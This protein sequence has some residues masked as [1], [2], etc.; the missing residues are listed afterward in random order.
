MIIIMK[1]IL[2]FVPFLFCC[3]KVTFASS[4]V[5]L[6]QDSGRVLKSENKDEPML[7]ASISKIMTCIIA[8]ENGD[9]NKMV[10]ADKSIL[11]AVG[12]SIYIEIGESITLK[13]LLY[14]MMLRSGNDAAVLIANS[15][16]GDMKTFSE[17]M[18]QYAK[19]I[20]MKN[21]VFYNSNGLE[22]EN[23]IGNKS[24]AYDMAILTSYAMKNKM[25]RE[26][27]KTKKY[28]A[29]SDKKIYVWENKNKLLKYDYITGGKT[30]YTKKAGRT[31]VTSATINNMH[32]IVV[33]LRDKNDWEN[34]KSFYNFVKN[35]YQRTLIFNKKS[36]EIVDDTLFVN[37]KLY[38]KNNVVLTLNKV[39]LSSLKIKYYLFKN[40]NYEE[41]IE[42]GNVKIYLN[43]QEVYSEPI[44]IK[45][46]NNSKE[47][48]FVRILK[49]LFKK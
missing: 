31:L 6:D 22:D 32:I 11:S 49:R 25:F 21:T 7:I 15:I 47:N 39:E 36:F 19:K 43:N 35:N 8:L 48:I 12:S 20:G 14:G 17:L 13:D 26:I 42:I 44:Y 28:T 10:K 40:K 30:G 27:F 16:S 37:D 38:I 33:T 5:V 18:N 45:K 3:I 23:G 4:Y 46:D 1:K 24:S 2:L 34:H 41:D 9:L 29:R